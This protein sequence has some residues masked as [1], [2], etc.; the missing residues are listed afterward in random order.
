MLRNPDQ[1]A[2]CFGTRQAIGA[3]LHHFFSVFLYPQ[4]PFFGMGFTSYVRMAQLSRLQRDRSRR[5]RYGNKLE[6]ARH[7]HRG[8][9]VN[10][11]CVLWLG[12]G[13]DE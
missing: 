2:W 11:S 13:R 7:F 3:R 5:I 12:I 10:V 9:E 1:R 6:L 8:H 4:T